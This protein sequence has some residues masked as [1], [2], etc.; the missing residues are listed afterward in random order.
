[1]VMGNNPL[2]WGKGVILCHVV[3]VPGRKARGAPATAGRTGR[4]LGAAAGINPAGGP[5]ARPAGAWTRAAG[6]ERAGAVGGT[7]TSKFQTNQGR[8]EHAGWQRDG[9][10]G[11][12]SPDG[13]GRR[14]LRR[15]VRFWPV[16]RDV[17][18]GSN[19]VRIRA[20]AGIPRKANQCAEKPACGAR[21]AT[22]GTGEGFQGNGL[23][24]R[25]QICRGR[26]MTAQVVLSRRIRLIP[27]V[28][29]LDGLPLVI[30]T[31]AV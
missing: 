14:F 23:R 6:L 30:Y 2:L 31:L 11:H 21:K 20:G 17:F 18:R 10:C 28:Y 3:T 16:A 7:V 1:M 9:T 25:V 13:Q 15:A 22:G 26:D 8:I 12:G 4:G 24:T 5:T 27:A 29:R 19:R